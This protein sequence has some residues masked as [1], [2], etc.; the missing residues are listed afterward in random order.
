MK[1]L[2]CGEEIVEGAA[3]CT[4]CGAKVDDMLAE[5][6]KEEVTTEGTELNEKKEKEDVKEETAEKIEKEEPKFKPAVKEDNEKKK[7]KNSKFGFI[8][9]VIV[10]VVA[11]LAGL[12]YYYGEDFEFFEE[13]TSKKSKNKE[14]KNQI[15]NTVVIE[16][17]KIDVNEIIDPKKEDKTLITT[18]KRDFKNGRAWSKSNGSWICIDE[19]G[20]VVFKLTEEYTDVTDFENANYSMISNYT[21]K[22]IINKN[23]DLITTDKDNQAFDRIVSDDVTAGCAVVQKNVSTSEKKEIQYGIIGFEGNWLLNLSADNDFLKEYKSCGVQNVLINGDEVYFISD[24]KKVRTKNGNITRV[25][26]EDDDYIYFYTMKNKL[27][28]VRKNASGDV[29]VVKKDIQEIGKYENGVVYIHTSTYNKK[30]KKKN[31][32]KAYFDLNGKEQIK[33]TEKNVIKVS[34]VS[35]NGTYGIIT[36]KSGKDYITL[37]DKDG[38]KIFEPIEGALECKYLGEG[39]FFMAYSNEDNSESY[40]LDESGNRIYSALIMGEYEDGYAIK[41]NNNYVDEKGMVLTIM[42][43]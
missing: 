18:S 24:A 38:K 17:N 33:I 19:N 27:I 13:N 25:I 35:E 23:G 37:I 31:E 14:E 42:D 32:N 12:I 9:I 29:Q 28:K 15:E 26:A 3:F 41:D 43:K 36:R 10:V 22:A 2:K 16:E 11:I 34:E 6:K 40:V 8:V 39:K 1:C 20:E 30:K 21:N 5:P 7:K 4:N